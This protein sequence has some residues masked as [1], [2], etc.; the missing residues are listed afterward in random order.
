MACSS[1][2]QPPLESVSYSV[3]HSKVASFPIAQ[4]WVISLSE[5]EP[6]SSQVTATISKS[7]SL[8]KFPT[9][10]V[11]SISPP[12]VN[13]YAELQPVAATPFSLNNQS[14]ESPLSVAGGCGTRI[15]LPE[16]SVIS[17][18]T[19]LG[20]I[21]CWFESL[22]FTIVPIVLGSQ[23][24]NF[25]PPWIEYISKLVLSY[26][27]TKTFRL[28]PSSNTAGDEISLPV[29]SNFHNSFPL[30]PSIA[31]TLISLDS[32]SIPEITKSLPPLNEVIAGLLRIIVISES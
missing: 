11:A 27:E 7:L 1:L 15:S 14:W 31:I 2:S 4:T 10:G 28:L 24:D 20:S 23:P 32:I 22:G 3:S 30:F 16:S 8:S 18:I 29:S 6:G 17:A 26:T 13:S 9:A 5:A 12:P 25:E 21:G 19:I